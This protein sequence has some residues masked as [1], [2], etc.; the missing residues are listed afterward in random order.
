MEKKNEDVTTL[1]IQGQNGDRKAMEQLL[2]A[3]YGPILYQCRHFLK[4]EA[5]AEDAAQEILLQIYTKLDT[6]REPAAFWGWVGRMTANRCKNALTRTHEDLPLAEGWESIPDFAD[7]KD[8][9]NVPE[10]AL[11]NAETARMIGEI[12]DTLPQAQ[13]DCVL[14]YYYDEMSV[15]EIAALLGVSQNTVKSRLYYARNTLQE[16]VLAYE[17]KQGIRLHSLAPIPLLLYFLYREAESSVEA[18]KAAQTVSAVMAQE[19][20]V[21]AASGAAPSAAKTVAAHAARGISRKTAALAGAGLVLL[22]GAALGATV[23]VWQ[24]KDRA[25]EMAARQEEQEEQRAEASPAAEVPEE[26]VEEETWEEPLFPAEK[27]AALPYTG[28]L[29]QCAMTGKQADAFAALLDGCLTEYQEYGGASCRAALFDAGEGIPAL[30]VTWYNDMGYGD[31]T[32]YMAF[33]SRI[34]C[35]D[36]ENA[37]VC[38]ELTREDAPQNIAVTDGGLIVNTDVY[39]LEGGMAK[40]AHV[41]EYFF[42]EDNTSPSMEQFQAY[43]SAHGAYQGSYDYDTLTQDKWKVYLPEGPWWLDGEYGTF[44]TALDGVFL[45]PEEAEEVGSTMSW[46]QAQW[47][48]GN[49]TMW[50]MDVSCNWAGDWMEAAQLADLLRDTGEEAGTKE[51]NTVESAAGEIRRTTLEDNGY[52]I[53]IWYEVPVFSGNTA[54]CQVVNAVYEE[55]LAAFVRDDTGEL[56]DVWDIVKD[57]PPTAESYYYT[58]S[59][60]VKAQTSRYVSVEQVFSSYLGGVR[61]EEQEYGNYRIDTGEALLLTDL[62]EEPE[63]QIKEE[64]ADALLQEDPYTE[65]TGALDEI[66]SRNIGDF[67]FYIEEGKIFVSFTTDEIYGISYGAD[68]PI[69]VELAAPLKEEWK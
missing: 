49:G 38:A 9:Q 61:D 68:E 10:E 11:D 64:I 5:D 28:D 62:L 22:G 63:G 6:L 30:F 32:G 67:A 20:P 17:K 41:Y 2:C 46:Y 39:T 43:I 4:K 3:A 15:Q 18:G 60:K 16:K 40:P 31:D 57:N 69:V 42:L 14:L 54:G 24:E 26:A 36:G 1:I 29:S 12:L 47:K 23:A 59:A 45:T 66:R 37:V 19:T 52:N 7:R 33:A 13:R 21:S 55:K 48:L 51:Q 8:R 44:V 56:A 65:Q 50:N 35:W 34:Y 27:L 25:V 53:E 58:V